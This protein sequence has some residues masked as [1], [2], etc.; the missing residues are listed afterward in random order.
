MTLIEMKNFDL[1]DYKLDSFRKLLQRQGDENVA[2][3][4]MICQIFEMLSKENYN[5][6]KVYKS[7]KSRIKQLQNGKKMYQRD[8]LG[9]EIVPFDQWLRVKSGNV[10]Y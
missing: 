4:R 1:V 5:Y 9:Y 8:L 3:C 6:D 7:Q 10:S 2:R